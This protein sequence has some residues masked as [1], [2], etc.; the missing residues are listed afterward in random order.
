[1]GKP[2]IVILNMI[3]VAQRRGIE[4]NATK[5]SDMLKCLV[6]HL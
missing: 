6:V 2:V 1:M 5:I 3:D 4:I